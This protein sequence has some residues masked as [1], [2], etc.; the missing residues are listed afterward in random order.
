MLQHLDMR[1]FGRHPEEFHPDST[2]VGAMATYVHEH[3]H[4]FQTIFTGF[5]HIV[6]SSHRHSTGYSIRIWKELA[7]KGLGYRLP[8]AAYSDPGG[9][10]VALIADVTAR[11]VARLSAARFPSTDSELDV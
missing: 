9:S 3:M 4:Y 1:L 5:G 10:P 2:T 11:E 7:R 8:L 6:W